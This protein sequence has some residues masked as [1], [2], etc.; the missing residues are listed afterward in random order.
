[1]TPIMEMSSYITIDNDRGYYRI[2]IREVYDSDSHFEHAS[3]VELY[4]SLYRLIIMDLKC[5]RTED[6]E[7]TTVEAQDRKINREDFIA[8]RE[9]YVIH[10]FREWYSLDAHLCE[11]D[12]ERRLVSTYFRHEWWM[13]AYMSVVLAFFGIAPLLGGFYWLG[14]VVFFGGMF[15]LFIPGIFVYHGLA[16]FLRRNQDRRFEPNYA[17]VK[18]IAKACERC[19]TIGYV[20]AIIGSCCFMKWW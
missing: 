4:D 3:N 14:C 9:G 5:G 16:D 15:L 20:V 17:L 2:E 7:R 18:R 6:W 1:M 12:R 11:L 13:L 19:A 8:H 10:F